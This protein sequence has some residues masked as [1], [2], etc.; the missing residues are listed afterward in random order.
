MSNKRNTE[1]LCIMAAQARASLQALKPLP[2]PSCDEEMLVLARGPGYV[3][4]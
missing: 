2:Q 3:P 1:C 4:Q